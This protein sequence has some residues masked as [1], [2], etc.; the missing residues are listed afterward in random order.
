MDSDIE[1]RSP[2]GDDRVA[3]RA[4]VHDLEQTHHDADDRHHDAEQQG[5]QLAVGREQLGADKEHRLVGQACRETS[6]IAQAFEH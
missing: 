4:L 5:Q 1:R 2:A 3:D 6:G